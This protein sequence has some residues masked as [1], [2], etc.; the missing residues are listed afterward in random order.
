M[1]RY[2]QASKRIIGIYRTELNEL[3]MSMY[4]AIY[5]ELVKESA[6]SFSDGWAEAVAWMMSHPNFTIDESVEAKSAEIKT[7]YP[8][9]KN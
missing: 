3:D 7:R 9:L 6:H 4:D 8:S 5:D 2:S 1:H